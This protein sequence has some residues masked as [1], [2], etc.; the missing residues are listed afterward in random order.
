M[1]LNARVRNV[2]FED[3]G[4]HDVLGKKENQEIMI[5]LCVAKIW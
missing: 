3:V 2:I 5:G 4:L 1:D